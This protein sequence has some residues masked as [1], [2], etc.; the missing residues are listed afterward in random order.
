[1]QKS[2]NPDE[3]KSIVLRKIANIIIS[4]DDVSEIVNRCLEVLGTSFDMDRVYVYEDD[5][6]GVFCSNT[7]EW[8]AEGIEAHI[9]SAKDLKIKDFLDVNYEDIFD[10]EGFFVAEDVSKLP[11]S[12]KNIFEKHGAKSAIQY[13]LYEGDYLRGIIGFD[14]CSKTNEWSKDVIHTLF[15]ASSLLGFL[16][17][18]E[19]RGSAFEEALN[20]QRNQFRDALLADAEYYYVADITED[21]IVKPPV[22]KTEKTGMKSLQLKFPMGF[23]DYITAWKSTLQPIYKE[24]YAFRAQTRDELIEAY[25]VGERNIQVD[26]K[27]RDRDIYCRKTTLLYKRKSDAHLIATV[28]IHDITNERIEEENHRALLEA[29]QNVYSSIF[30]GNLADNTAK[31]LRSSAVISTFVPTSGRMDDLIEIWAGRA[32]SEEGYE[33]NK[34]FW[35]RRLIRERL[36]NTNMIT[37]ELETIN[38]GWIQISIVVS[39]RDEEGNPVKV[40][41]LTRVIDAEKK[42]QIKTKAELKAAKKS[43]D[44]DELTGLYNRH[45]FN[46]KLKKII[47]DNRIHSGAAIMMDIDDFKVINDTYGHDAGD[48]VLKSIAKTL[49]SVIRH[50]D[51]FCRWGGEEFNAFICSDDDP[52]IIAKRIRQTVEETTVVY[53]GNS[54]NVTISIGVCIASDIKAV[55][56]ATIIN[57]ADKCLYISKCNGKN[58]ITVERI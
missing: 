36:K 35:D 46:E 42:E 16:L 32:L 40:L 57:K 1:M 54:I 45:S 20:E 56:T 43:A 9:D 10:E 53:E 39:A 34:D 28:V 6:T 12:E 52:E 8:C 44:H 5:F 23:D 7:F 14:D 3:Y 19:R 37:R 48:Q 11:E 51:V 24:T 27:L 50:D 49:V 13:G 2:T 17:L 58:R 41:W 18:K 26:Y 31:E 33:Q 25:D 29:L 47:D 22:F 15:M 21:V 4:T 38:S 55:S 30:E